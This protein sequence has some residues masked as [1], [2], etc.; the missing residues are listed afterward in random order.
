MNS[1]GR[2]EQRTARTRSSENVYT[3][4]VCSLNSHI[5]MHTN[6]K[7]SICRL[8]WLP[9]AKPRLLSSNKGFPGRHRLASTKVHI[10][11]PPFTARRHAQYPVVCGHCRVTGRR[12]V[13]RVKLRHVTPTP[14]E[15]GPTRNGERL[16]EARVSY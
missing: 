15:E 2:N 4:N 3:A 7:P 14:A 13:T 9:H 11:R 8:D 12:D 16:H 1:N 5:R 6:A 10:A